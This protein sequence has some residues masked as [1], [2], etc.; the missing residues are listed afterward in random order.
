MTSTLLEAVRAQQLLQK[1]IEHLLREGQDLGLV[2]N[3][4]VINVIKKG[5][6]AD[7]IAG[8]GIVE[9][10]IEEAVEAEV[11]LAREEVGEMILETARDVDEMTDLEMTILYTLTP[12]LEVDTVVADPLP[13]EVGSADE[14]AE[15]V[16]EVL[17]PIRPQELLTE[18]PSHK[19]LSE[20]ARKKIES[21]LAIYHSKS[22]GTI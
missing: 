5:Q 20:A 2:V 1:T 17:L 18:K 14:E 6:E 9:V 22:D 15:A 4:L 7:P 8:R 11:D 10:V 19:K 21:T 16:E 12:R 3:H 13:E